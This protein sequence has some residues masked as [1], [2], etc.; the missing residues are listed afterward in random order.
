MHTLS[1]SRA[2][3]TFTAPYLLISGNLP[4]N[5]GE[6]L[7]SLLNYRSKMPQSIVQEMSEEEIKRKLR[8]F[9][10]SGKAT[11]PEECKQR[12]E[13]LKKMTPLQLRRIF[14]LDDL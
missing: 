5:Q 7:N 6:A 11:T 8:S 13:E 1:I 10:G 3:I 4:E 2:F 12:E 14:G 9:I